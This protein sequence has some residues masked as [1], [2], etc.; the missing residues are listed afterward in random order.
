MPL[1][2]WTRKKLQKKKTKNEFKKRSK[3]IKFS[4]I[5]IS[6]SSMKYKRIRKRYTW[7]WS[8]LKTESF[9]ILLSKT[10]DFKK[11]KLQNYFH[12][13]WMELNTYIKPENL[14]ININNQLKII[15]FGLSNIYSKNEYLKTACGSPCYASPEMIKGWK[16]SGL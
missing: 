10:K 13:F 9:L 5:Q 16:Y 3:Y 4:S 14:L 2:F 7:L 6:Y 8:M 15:D 1:K 12:S 11:K